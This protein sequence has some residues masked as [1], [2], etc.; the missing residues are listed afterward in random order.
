[1]SE[2]SGQNKEDA[3]ASFF[4]CHGD[5]KSNGQINIIIDKIYHGVAY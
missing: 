3:Y 1:M 4:A 2:F 5:K